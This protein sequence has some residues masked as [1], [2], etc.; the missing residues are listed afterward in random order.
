MTVYKFTSID[1][2]LEFIRPLLIEGK[3]SVNVRTF[4]K[5]YPR[6]YDIDHF[7]VAV[8]ELDKEKY[9]PP[10]E[11]VDWTVRNKEPL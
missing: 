2:T 8:K 5:D 9:I 6:E 11:Q 4:Y 1:R 3:Y 7:E 10:L